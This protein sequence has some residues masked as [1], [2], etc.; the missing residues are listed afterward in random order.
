MDLALKLVEIICTIF[1]TIAFFISIVHRSKKYL[2]PIQLYI[3][4]CLILNIIDLAFGFYGKNQYRFVMYAIYNI[5]TIFEIF[6]ILYFFYVRLKRKGFRNALISFIS[7]FLLICFV[8][9]IKKESAFFLY[10]PAL[11]GIE[12]FLITSA[13]LLYLYE[14]LN[15]DYLEDL[16]SNPNFIIT[17]GILFNFGITVPIYFCWDTLFNL[18]PGSYRILSIISQICFNILIISIVKAYLCPIPNHQR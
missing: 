9:W 10:I 15:N 16:K 7:F 11:L 13:S 17:C 8:L 3:F 14:I 12:A 5:Q 2:F 18:A 4:S 1:I 6:L